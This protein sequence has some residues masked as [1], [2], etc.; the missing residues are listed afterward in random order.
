MDF[1]FI[2]LE[3]RIYAKTD[4]GKVICEITFPETEKG[5]CNIDHTYVDDDYRGMGLA[6]KLVQ[7][8]VDSIEKRGCKVTATCS[9]AKHWLDKHK[10]INFKEVF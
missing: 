3:D 8:A 6:G 1:K 9:Y 7:E 2:R 10:K 5:V 4:E